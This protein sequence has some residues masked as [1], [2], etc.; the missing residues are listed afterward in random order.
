MSGCEPEGRGFGSLL[1]PQIDLPSSNGR[2]AGFEPVDR[3][4]NPR[5]RPISKGIKIISFLNIPDKVKYLPL[6]LAV[7]PI[8]GLSSFFTGL[9]EFLCRQNY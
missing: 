6:L 3:G 5:G 1:S 2:I 9:K 8:W 4:S 7:L